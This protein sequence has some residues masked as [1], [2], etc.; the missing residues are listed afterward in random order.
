MTA[1]GLVLLF[2]SRAPVWLG[3]VVALFCVAIA[4]WAMRGP[5]HGARM[6]TRRD[7]LLSHACAEGRHSD[8]A[9]LADVWGFEKGAIIA[10]DCG[11]HPPGAGGEAIRAESARRDQER[12]ERKKRYPVNVRTRAEWRAWLAANHGRELGACLFYDDRREMT[13]QEATDEALC[14]GW[15][16]EDLDVTDRSQLFEPRRKGSFWAPYHR[17]RYSELVRAGLMT[18]A[19]R[20][21]GPETEDPP[22]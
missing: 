17:A 10:C 19:G 9:A 2:L 8:C 11:C 22:G 21:V 5:K 20:A 14:F 12:L 7:P 1:A 13:F 15:V 18:E 3:A 6:M 16:P 4:L